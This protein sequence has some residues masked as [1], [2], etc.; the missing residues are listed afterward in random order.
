MAARIL[1][2]E[3]HPTNLQLMV[4]LLHAF[5]YS[6]LSAPD[7]AAGLE[8]AAQERPDLI[9]C[10]VH[11]PRVDGYEV[12]RRLKQDPLLRKIPLVAVTALAMVGDRERLLEAGF[13][14]YIGKPIT[15]ETFVGEV[16]KFLRDDLRSGVLP[17]VTA[18]LEA[19]P[20][21]APDRS[22]TVL[23]V[24]DSALNLDLMRSMLEPSGYRV[25]T[26]TSVRE[27]LLLAHEDRPDVIVSD[28]QMPDQSGFDFIEAVKRD[29]VLCGIPFMFLSS[30][31]EKEEKH[32][33]ILGADAFIVRPIEPQ[34]L[35]ATIAGCVQMRREV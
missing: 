20:G 2:V 24:D 33:R 21:P 1:I 13:D 14:G 3:D 15:P 23:V 9:L 22:G 11:L 28:V 27:G 18:T 4:Y 8:A 25:V 16:E 35:L 31:A 5:G 10:D 17:V 12:A 7:G 29:P 34:D 6:L 26:A 30:T 32:G 19:L